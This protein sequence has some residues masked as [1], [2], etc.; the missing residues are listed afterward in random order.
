VEQPRET[1]LHAQPLKAMVHHTE[2]YYH[3]QEL[4][5]QTW[6]WQSSR[7]NNKITW[8]PPLHESKIVE[9]NKAFAYLQ[10][11]RYRNF[12]WEGDE[13]NPHIDYGLECR[14][15]PD[16]GFKVYPRKSSRA[17]AAAR[18]APASRF[19]RQKSIFKDWQWEQHLA[20]YAKYE[21]CLWTLSEMIGESLK[22]WGVPRYS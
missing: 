7:M 20:N 9:I 5:Y 18:F 13:T 16:V 22:L 10:H 15:D 21:R 19:Y 3:Q 4:D 12:L 14:E 17:N 2:Q 11:A 6:L 8:T 1:E